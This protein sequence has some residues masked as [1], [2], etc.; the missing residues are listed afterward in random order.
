M[1]DFDWSDLCV[2]LQIKREY[3]VQ[4]RW[5]GADTGLH[6]RQVHFFIIFTSENIVATYDD[7]SIKSFE[8]KNF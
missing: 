6:D 8:L 7:G 3:K 2:R 1:R 5:R 4:E